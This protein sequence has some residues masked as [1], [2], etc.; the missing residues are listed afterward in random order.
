MESQA[1]PPPLLL[2]LLLSLCLMG[3][4]VL[5]KKLMFLLRGVSLYLS[6]CFA[7]LVHAYTC[8]VPCFREGQV[9]CLI[10]PLQLKLMG[11][12]EGGSAR[13][14]SGFPSVLGAFNQHLHV[15]A[16][17]AFSQPCFPS[18]VWADQSEPWSGSML[19]LMLSSISGLVMFSVVTVLLRFLLTP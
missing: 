16:S 8:W 9:L 7:T 13:L 10:L 1:S 19:R 18:F 11:G 6:L 14:S 5:G 2:F 17:S 4:R 3:L 15:P 12:G